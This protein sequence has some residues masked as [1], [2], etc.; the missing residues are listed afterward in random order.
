MA[1]VGGEYCDCDWRDAAADSKPPIREEM[2]MLLLGRGGPTRP[3]KS[4]PVWKDGGGGPRCE[5]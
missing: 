5:A 1:E 4:R 3:G 2:D